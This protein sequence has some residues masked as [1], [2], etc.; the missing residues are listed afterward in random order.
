[1]SPKCAE[2][3]NNIIVESQKLMKER[4]INTKRIR[5]AAICSVCAEPF[6]NHM[7]TFSKILAELGN[8]KN[9]IGS[10]S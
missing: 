9:E 7:N 5:M 2:Y 8:V 4:N 1:Y 10:N 6:V 3:T